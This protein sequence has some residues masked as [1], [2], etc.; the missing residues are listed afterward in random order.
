MDGNWL[1]THCARFDHG[2]CGLRVLVENGKATKVEPDPDDPFSYG[3]SCPKGMA[4]LERIS[5]PKRLT[6]P[7]RRQGAR[8]EGKWETISWDQA[9]DLLTHH[10]SA[11]RD[12]YGPEGL[13]FAQGAP[14]GLEFFM[15]LRLANLLGTPNVGGTQHVCHMPREQM[16]MVTCGFFPVADLEGRPQ[17][18]LLWGSNPLLTNEEGVLGGHLMRCLQ[19]G[20]KLVVI[21]PL[22]TELARRAD[23]WLQIR[24]GTDDFLALG[25]L[26]ILMEEGLFDRDFVANWTLGFEALHEAVRPY[27]PEKV[28]QATW[29]P[30]EKLVAAARLYG[31]LRPALMQWGNAIE[32]TIN[33][34]Q[35]CRALVLLMA[36]TGNLEAPGGNIRA[37]APRLKRLSE[38]LCLDHFPD[39]AQKLLNR[40]YGMIPRLL[41]VPG[42]VLM[43]CILQQSPYPVRCLYA[44]GTNPM[45]SYAEV[46]EVQAALSRL[47]FLAVADQ[48]LTPTAALADLVLPVATNLEFND[49]G[50]YGLPHGYVLARPKVV[51]PRA[52][53]WPDVK[54]LNEWGRRMGLA[55]YFWEDVDQALDEILE[56]SGITYR[57]F[58]QNGI[59]R[60]RK[61][62]HTYRDKGFAT[63]SG[64]VELHSSLLEKWGYAPLP[65][66]LEPPPTT[67]DYPLLLTS[68]KPRLFFHSAYRHLDSLRK[69]SP[70]PRVLLHPA[71]AHALAIHDGD[72][73]RIVTGSGSLVQEAQLTAGVDPRVVVADYGWWFPEKSEETLFGFRE[74]NLNCLTR[75]GPGFDPIMGTTQLRALPCRLETV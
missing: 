65:S 55:E 14:K 24:P 68:R 28:A 54:I 57:E 73:V 62:Y 7:M 47:D 51:E 29:I 4:T 30:R 15:L 1:R 9:L 44:Q 66:A 6:H 75:V 23:I 37:Q 49:L 41:T 17:C 46:E 16:A 43:R 59:L 63:P 32:H 48:V 12:R 25:M 50:H 71:T 13:A 21:D 2:G 61:A 31:R 45:V 34:A 58:A 10:F 42:W 19:Y 60:G 39:R 69:R 22:E 70:R 36:I 11:T 38:F 35:T 74:S 72:A 33:S 52:E 64:K 67:E 56:P 53:C 18:V 27:A 8:G 20:P 3:Y 5:H 26:H 40:S